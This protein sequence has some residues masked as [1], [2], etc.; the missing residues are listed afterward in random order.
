[1]IE[2]PAGKPPR[3]TIRKKEAVR[4]LLHAAIRM[5]TSQED[6][7]AV[8]MLAHSADK[9]LIDLSKRTRK[10]LA[11]DWGA[12]PLKPEYRGASCKKIDNFSLVW[13]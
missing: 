7:F 6:C 12:E 10:P 8:Q 13:L 5:V 11:M 3:R 1:M 9:L 4:H 2:K